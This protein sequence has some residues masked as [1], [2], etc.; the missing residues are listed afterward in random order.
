[1][2]YAKVDVK[3]RD[4]ARAHRAGVAMAT[5]TWALLYVREQETDGFVP[6]IAL[7]GAWV[8]ERAAREH[9]RKLVE[10]GLWDEAEE[11]WRIRRYD[12]KNDTKDA[13]AARREETRERVAR[14]R[15]NGSRN[16]VT[17]G[18][19]N[20]L[21]TQPSA[22]LVPGSRSRSGSERSDSREGVQGEGLR[23][24]RPDEPLTA[25]RAGYVETVRMGTGANLDAEAIW[26]N[27]VNDR[28][29]KSMVFGSEGAIDADWRK[30]VDR[31]PGFQRKNQG[32]ARGAEITKQPYDKNAPWMKV[33]T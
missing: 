6:D 13:I 12:E 11:G 18:A 8:G 3:L 33:G 17:E 1:M 2:I 20:A 25:A 14:F 21:L 31:E 4:H 9:A 27:Y 23:P 19:C 15:R 26:R 32:A 7:R 30:W 28:I 16:A 22:A 10:V 5:W 29:A 24:I